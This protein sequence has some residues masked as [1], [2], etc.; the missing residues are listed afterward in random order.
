MAKAKK[1]SS[2]SKVY[3]ER[4]ARWE[5]RAAERKKARPHGTGGDWLIDKP[6]LE[7]D[8]VT[9]LKTLRCL[10]RMTQDQRCFD[11]HRDLIAGDL[12]DPAT[13]K[14]ARWGTTLA[15]SD[16]RFMCELINEDIA[17]RVFTEREVIAAAVDEIDFDAASF[18]AACARVKELL[19]AYRATLVREKPDKKTRMRKTGQKN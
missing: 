10:G 17:S 13:G 4:K 16:T 14:W 19:H 1:P 15:Q 11:L 5:A 9:F 3:S 8:A 12:I 7:M 18:D 6:E 2:R